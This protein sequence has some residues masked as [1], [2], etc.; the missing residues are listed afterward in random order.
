MGLGLGEVS[1]CRL[2]AMPAAIAICPG[3]HIADGC[4]R[5][6]HRSMKS[7]LLHP[8][9][10]VLAVAARSATA[11]PTDAAAPPGVVLT[12]QLPG[13]AMQRFTNTELGALPQAELIQRRTV[14][15]TT[16]AAE[17]G[18]DQGVRYGGVLL[19]DVI[20]R[21]GS[22]DPAAQRAQRTM[23]FEA[24]AT[25]GYRA[26]FSWGEL[27]NSPLGAQVLVIARQDGQPIAAAEGPLALRSLAD[28]RPGPRH[29]RNFCGLVGKLP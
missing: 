22:P 13:A 18:V 17:P 6:H 1:V 25:D 10:A 24:V 11:C 21:V 8:L 23:V 20:A 4:R 12:V 27:I 29:V 28:L 16:G 9:A 2:F 3:L 7:K 26:V 19:R 15:A 14:T 5:W